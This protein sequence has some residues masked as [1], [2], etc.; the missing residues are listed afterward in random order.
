MMPREKF[1]LKKLTQ[2]G[3]KAALA[4][5][6]RYRLLNEPEPA[7]SI[8]LDVLEVEPDNQDALQMLILT[9]TD[10]FGSSSGS[11]VRRAKDLVE[12]IEDEYR[13]HYLMGLVH[14]REGRSALRRSLGNQATYG[15]QAAYEC[16]RDAMD[17]YERAEDLR[18]EGIDDP[19][20]RWNS[21]VRIIEREKLTPEGEA[22]EMQLE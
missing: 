6:E 7:E 3:V 21:C 18:P 17:E 5:A 11:R 1:E 10:Q 19:I 14:E 20:L 9:L 4:K 2:M 8:C 12:L 16:L 15:N 13:R 22:A